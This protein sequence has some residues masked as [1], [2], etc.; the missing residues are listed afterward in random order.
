[1]G[2]HADFALV[3]DTSDLHIQGQGG[4]ITG[5]ITIKSKKTFH[6]GTRRE[7]I[8]AGGKLFGASAIEKMAKVIGG[9]QE[10]ETTLGS[11]EKLSGFPA[12]N[13]YD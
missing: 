5:W 7:M 1:M 12:W 13:E 3:V 2:I 6:D 4:V 10:L 8:H 11:D 9:L